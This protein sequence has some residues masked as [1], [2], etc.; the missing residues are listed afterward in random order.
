MNILGILSLLWQV[1][2][3]VVGNETINKAMDNWVNGTSNKYDDMVW[4]L[5]EQ[6]TGV[7]DA[8]LQKTMLADG[9]DAIEKEYV[10]DK[11][12]GVLA[13]M[14]N[15]LKTWTPMNGDDF[16]SLLSGDSV[17]EKI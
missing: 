8:E 12:A 7:A 5:L 14:K 6:V 4:K 16:R 17:L 13:A 1:L 11:E 10:T 9:L 15:P 3:S 2:K